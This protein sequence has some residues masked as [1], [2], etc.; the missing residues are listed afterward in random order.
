METVQFYFRK[1]QNGACEQGLRYWLGI[2]LISVRF[3]QYGL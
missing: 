1:F 3:G 2:G